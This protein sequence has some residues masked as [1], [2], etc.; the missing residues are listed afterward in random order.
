M[1]IRQFIEQSN[2]AL[3]L[4]EIS[5]L[6]L[7]D[8]EKQHEFFDSV[9]QKGLEYLEYRD[10][11]GEQYEAMV[12]SRGE[13]PLWRQIERV[14]FK[15]KQKHSSQPKTNPFRLVG[16]HGKQSNCIAT[17]CYNSKKSLGYL[18]AFFNR[19]GGGEIFKN[20]RPNVNLTSFI[21]Y[22]LNELK[23]EKVLC[24]TLRINLDVNRDY[25][26]NTPEINAARQEALRCFQ[27]TNTGEAS[28]PTIR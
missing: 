7:F 6:P 14:T 20:G 16:R 5:V 8:P 28:R 4:T 24:E 1:E 19:Q 2:N 17:T 12:K 15:A 22:L 11:Q 26:Q 21:S 23:A 18:K 10:K 3:I 27:A 13:Q 9:V 25:T